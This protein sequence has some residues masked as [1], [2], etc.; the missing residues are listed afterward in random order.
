MK[1]VYENKAIMRSEIASA[2]ENE[3]NK[4]QAAQLAERT[5]VALIKDFY[6]K[7]L[8]EVEKVSSD[9]RIVGSTSW[10]QHQLAQ[11]QF[12]QDQLGSVFMTLSIDLPQ[13]SLEN[14]ATAMVQQGF[15]V[16]IDKIGSATGEFQTCYLV[17]LD[18][19]NDT[20]C[21]H[22][23]STKVD[24][25]TYLEHENIKFSF[26]NNCVGVYVSSIHQK[27]NAIVQHII[28]APSSGIVAEDYFT[29]LV[30]YLDG[31]ATMES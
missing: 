26:G 25:Q 5:F 1:K 19:G 12:M 24:L 22:Q 23:C 20:D 14:L 6:T 9:F 29:R 18:H 15:V 7:K 31:N 21:D 16:T 2:Y 30:F 27:M 10:F 3:L 28:K 4:Y 13:A 8:S 11:L 17:H